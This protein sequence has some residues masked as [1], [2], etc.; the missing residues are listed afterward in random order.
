MTVA[1]LARPVIRDLPIHLPIQSLAPTFHPTKLQGHIETEKN[2][3]FLSDDKQA[4]R[5]L[6]REGVKGMLDK[7][8]TEFMDSIQ[9]DILLEWFKTLSIPQ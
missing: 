9:K 6:L 8:R 4:N 1:V 2:T 5:E 3:F 7:V